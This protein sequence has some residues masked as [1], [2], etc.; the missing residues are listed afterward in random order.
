MASFTLLSVL[1]NGSPTLA[2]HHR[3]PYSA[4]QAG[5]VLVL[6]DYAKAAGGARRHVGLLP[7]Q[8]LSALFFSQDAQTLLGFW[9]SQGG[10]PMLT[11]WSV[12][13]TKKIA[14]S[15]LSDQVIGQTLW[16]DYHAETSNVVLLSCRPAAAVSVIHWDRQGLQPQYLCFGHVDVAA[17]SHDQCSGALGVRLL[18]DGCHFLVAEAGALRFWSYAERT[19][20]LVL[21]V[22]IGKTVLGF[23]VADNRVYLLPQKGR[24]RVMN[25]DGQLEEPSVAPASGAPGDAFTALAVRKSMACLGTADGALMLYG[26]P[27]LELRRRIEP[28]GELSRGGGSSITVR[29]HNGSLLPGCA[30]S[31]LT[32]GMNEDYACVCF[33][34]CTYGVVHLA[35]GQY[36]ALRLGHSSGVRALAIAPDLLLPPQLQSRLLEPDRVRGQK[37]LAFI[38]VGGDATGII[39]WPRSGPPARRALRAP[40]RPGGD[41][42]LGLESFAPAASCDPRLYGGHLSLTSACFSPAARLA[43]DGRLAGAYH[44]LVGGDDGSLLLLESSEDTG[45]TAQSELAIAEQSGRGVYRLTP[46]A[47]AAGPPEQA[48]LPRPFDWRLV[49]IRPSAAAYPQ[50]SLQASGTSTNGALARPTGPVCCHTHFS[51][52]GRFVLAAFS[53]GYTELLHFPVMERALVIEQAG[54]DLTLGA[55]GKAFFVWHPSVEKRSYDR[56]MYVAS[57]GSAGRELVLYEIYILGNSYAKAS[58]RQFELPADCC[59]TDFCIHPSRLY[60][61]ASVVVV[62]S[63]P[64]A[65]L[66]VYDLWQGKMLRQCPIFESLLFTPVGPLRPEVTCDATGAQL[67]LMSSRSVVTKPLDDVLAPFLPP[68]MQLASAGG[69]D[70]SSPGSISD[71][72]FAAAPARAA[73]SREWM[74]DPRAEAAPPSCE[75]GSLLCIVD[76]S[77]GQLVYQTA[78]EASCFSLGSLAHEPAQIFLGGHDGSVSLWRPPE[79]VCANIHDHLEAVRQEAARQQVQDGRAVEPLSVSELEEAIAARWNST[80]VQGLDWNN[81][82]R[83]ACGR[84]N[85]AS[86][87]ESPWT[88]GWPRQ[89]VPPPP[90]LEA[91]VVQPQSDDVVVQARKSWRRSRPSSAVAPAPALPQP[92]AVPSAAAKHVQA[93]AAPWLQAKTSAPSIPM[94]RDPVSGLE[95][96]TLY[97]WANCGGCGQCLDCLRNG[98]AHPH[99]HKED[100]QPAY[101]GALMTDE[102]D[103]TLAH[104][105]IAAEDA[106]EYHEL[107]GDSPEHLQDPVPAS[108][109]PFR[110]GHSEGGSGPPLARWLEKAAYPTGRPSRRG[111]AP[112]QGARQAVYDEISRFE[113][114]NA[115][116]H[117]DCSSESDAS[118]AADAADA[119]ASPDVLVDSTDT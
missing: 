33:A 107:F 4:Y 103:V 23:D 115:G 86:R 75:L 105:R 118:G 57:L 50:G 76:F 32:L 95:E 24:V 58:H 7:G 15:Q 14:E 114:E 39:A 80:L 46:P 81:W 47:A 79:Q 78:L 102:A 94:A 34:D 100:T 98:R 61:I 25:F 1:G 10:Q 112:D 93:V 18:D 85:G 96:P 66:F 6:W 99:S 2:T 11:V 62:S 117:D 67:Y 29:S 44:L 65:R 36:A 77:T 73:V 60:L 56:N 51:L 116:L 12:A 83:A 26:V 38:S 35:S 92:P 31:S 59:V 5:S 109:P 119:P 3:F 113:I 9:L 43:G 19:P 88:P 91:A 54:K 106:P 82:G 52:C 53:N 108:P 42:S 90:G 48:G 40:P 16:A 84:P 20:R 71:C 70:E 97:P 41:N 55:A 45:D 74:Q 89:A 69:V 63:T 8:R 37:A 104:A 110:N 22:D 21:K 64:R 30:V 101:P 87:M 72:V 49:R 13:E 17:P 28:P 68:A 27:D 111:K